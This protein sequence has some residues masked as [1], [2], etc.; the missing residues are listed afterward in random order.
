MS[1]DASEAIMRIELL[2][3]NASINPCPM[4]DP[5]IPPRTVEAHKEGDLP[6]TASTL[7]L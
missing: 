2:K 4:A 7:K 1:T 3:E 6:E 5:P